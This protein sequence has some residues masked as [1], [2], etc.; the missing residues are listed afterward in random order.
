M[1]FLI[2]IVLSF[3]LTACGDSPLLNKDSS[4]K[5]TSEKFQFESSLSFSNIRAAQS[6]SRGNDISANKYQV[7]GLWQVGPNLENEN[8]ILIVISDADGN[9]TDLPLKLDPYIWMA[10]MGHGS[11]PIKVTKVE[12]GL[13]ELSE[14]FFTMGGYWDFHLDFL[15]QDSIIDGVKWP[16][17]L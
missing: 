15:F 10:G 6:D 1:K 14:I 3:M 5:D 16:I 13:Y 8:K 2:L 7:Q 9:R 12:T 17:N 4:D 11:F